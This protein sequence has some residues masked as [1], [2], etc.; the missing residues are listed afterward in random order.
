MRNR[1][2]Q[3]DIDEILSKADFH[4]YTYKNKTT[5]VIATL[6][7]GFTITESSSCVDPANYDVAIGTDICKERI[8][9]KIWELEGY[10]LQREV[11]ARRFE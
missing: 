3:T 6:P 4:V 1:V 9:N 8:Q 5:V 2:T 10:V 11:Y 7:N